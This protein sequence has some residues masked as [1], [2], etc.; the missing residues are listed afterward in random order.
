MKKDLKTVQPTHS[1][2]DKPAKQRILETSDKMFR[3]FGIRVS[4]H[5]IAHEA[6]S[7]IDTVLKHFGHPQR[8]ISIFLK[9]LIQEAENYWREV[10]GKYPNDPEGRLRYWMFFEEGRRD[11]RFEPERLLARSAA[12]LEVGSRNPLLAEIEQYWQAERR[13][14]VRLCEAAGFRGPRELADKLLL[15]VHGLRNERGAYGHHAPSRL[16]HQA[17]DDLMVAHGA[18]RKALLSWDD[19]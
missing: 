15:L 12:E 10:E 14:V 16:L 4:P 9:S 3:I 13:R 1:L 17:A 6:T 7:N 8:L 2:L 11:D 18:T 19:D 5:S